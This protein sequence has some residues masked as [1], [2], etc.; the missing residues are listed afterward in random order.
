MTA[1]EILKIAV[2]I[3]T[4]LTGAVSL[5]WPLKVRGF[6]GLEV[7]GGR[8]ITEIRAVLG[9]FFVG[10]GA[11]VI[12]LNDPA[13]YMTLGIAYLVVAGVRAISMFVDKSVERSN[14]ISVIT[15]VVFGVVL[16]L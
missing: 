7:S 4:I 3:A 8:G 1:L 11:A 15:E 6:T 2:A 10:L 12:I 9:G 14:V 16:V 13:A 5:F